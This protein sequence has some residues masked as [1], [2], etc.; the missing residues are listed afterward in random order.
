MVTANNNIQLLHQ[1]NSIKRLS[2]KPAT[3]DQFGLKMEDIDEQPENEMNEEELKQKT[4]LSN[5]E[6]I[7]EEDQQQQQQDIPL[8]DIE[9]ENEDEIVQEQV[10]P[11]NSE[12]RCDSG[13]GEPGES[14]SNRSSLLSS[15]S[16]H[17]PSDTN[18]PTPVNKTKCDCG[19]DGCDGHG[20]FPCNDTGQMT[21]ADVSSL[22]GK[23]CCFL[24]G[25]QKI[26][27]KDYVPGITE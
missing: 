23:V 22:P 8:Q 6:K 15:N 10:I 9:E 17:L 16:V 24:N 27:E 1:A 7:E 4:E 18:S 19:Q 12:N 2:V 13:F 21:D 11:G 14:L 5:E 25:F 26:Q 3:S 20:R